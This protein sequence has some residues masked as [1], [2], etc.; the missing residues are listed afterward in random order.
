VPVRSVEFTQD[1]SETAFSNARRDAKWFLERRLIED[2]IVDTNIKA[3]QRI[4]FQVG[5]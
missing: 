1:F 4:G 3:Y 5:V 2:V